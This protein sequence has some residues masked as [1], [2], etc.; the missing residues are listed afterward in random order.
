MKPILLVWLL[1]GLALAQQPAPAPAPD[2]GVLSIFTDDSLAPTAFL[3]S[4]V[5]DS[6]TDWK[7]SVNGKQYH[8]T[9]AQRLEW[10][11]GALGVALAVRHYWPKTGKYVNLALAVASAWFAGRAY[12]ATLAHG[13]PV[14]PAAAAAATP[15]AFP[16]R[17]K[18]K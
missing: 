12:A 15:A 13:T 14:A 2:R 10:T 16:V 4:Q 9:A 8:L 18:L 6:T 1:A 7:F 3:L 17:L 11:G 5:A